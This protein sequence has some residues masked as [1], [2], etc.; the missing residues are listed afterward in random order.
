VL[1]RERGLIMNRYP[2]MRVR[3]AGLSGFTLVEL[4][5]VIAI[6][7]VLVGLLL[8]AVQTARETA[9]TS[10]CAN[11][12]RQAGHAVLL[13]ESAQKMFPLVNKSWQLRGLR[14]TSGMSEFFGGVVPIL[15]YL[16]EVKR[17]NDICNGI[18]ASDGFAPWSGGSGLDTSPEILLCPSDARARPVNRGGRVPGKSYLCNIGDIVTGCYGGVWPRSV[19]ASGGSPIGGGLLSNNNIAAARVKLKDVTDGTSKSLMLSERAVGTGTIADKSVK[20]GFAV[21]VAMG[22]NTKPQLCLDQVIDGQLASTYTSGASVTRWASREDHNNVF[23]TILPPN[24]PSCTSQGSSNG[25][26]TDDY[27]LMTASSYHPGGVNAVMAD[28]AVRFVSEL[29]DAG[30]PNQVPTTVSSSHL[31]FRGQSQWGVW[32][33]LGTMKGGEALSANDF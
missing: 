22:K 12:L 32:G 30:D 21:G 31:N 2:R 23:Y 11:K 14:P 33:A 6:I 20:S 28:G 4:L 18:A 10:A 13:F 27:A 19:F 25:Y 17:Y 8:P 7:G 3:G 1:D 24:G 29:I 26:A 9:R 5:A 15:P 16:E